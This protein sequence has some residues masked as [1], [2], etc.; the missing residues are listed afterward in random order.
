MTRC[1]IADE[2]SMMTNTI[3][4]RINQR[5]ESMSRRMTNVFAPHAQFRTGSS[6]T[7]IFR[8]NMHN[9][10]RIS[11]ILSILSLKFHIFVLYKNGVAV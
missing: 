1:H 11:A 5:L 4:S 10:S 9:Q 3:T 6:S 2:R 7:L 8:R